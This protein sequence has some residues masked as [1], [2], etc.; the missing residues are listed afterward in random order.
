MLHAQFINYPGF[1]LVSHSLD[2][3][4]CILE[5]CD[6]RTLLS[7]SAVSMQFAGMVR[8]ELRRRFETYMKNILAPTVTAD[9]LWLML[10]CEGAGVVGNV[11]LAVWEPGC[12]MAAR[13][14]ELSIPA[15]HVQST[16]EWFLARGYSSEPMSV[17]SEVA[18]V[19]QSQKLLVCSTVSLP[20]TLSKTR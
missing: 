1:D 2:L 6:A 14:L 16:E 18:D 19:V 8:T 10:E 17:P 9:A 4:T 20:P 5:H 3:W 12:S 11:A 7:L 13:C 15:H